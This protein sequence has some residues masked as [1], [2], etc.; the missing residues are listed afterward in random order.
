MALPS[1][2]G[3]LDWK[4]RGVQMMAAGAVVGLAKACC[5]CVVKVENDGRKL[6]YTH[7]LNGKRLPIYDAT[8]NLLVMECVIPDGRTVRLVFLLDACRVEV[9]GGP[10]DTPRY[11]LVVNRASQTR[12]GVC[13]E[14]ASAWRYLMPGALGAPSTGK[15]WGAPAFW[16]ADNNA[17]FPDECNLSAGRRPQREVGRRRGPRRRLTNKLRELPKVQDLF[18]AVLAGLSNCVLDS[19]Q[20]LSRSLRSTGHARG[21]ALCGDQMEP[22]MFVG[23]PDARWPTAGDVNTSWAAEDIPSAVR[24]GGRINPLLMMTVVAS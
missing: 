11:Q 13:T 7:P 18:P 17:I 3:R 6:Y 2:V 12:N 14:V 20:L 1:V 8:P 16:D 22:S 4:H 21:V 19:A 15:D 9:R 5:G 24:M 23:P 10:E